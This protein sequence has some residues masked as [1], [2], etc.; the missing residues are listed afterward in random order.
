[1]GQSI[2][3][4]GYW[5]TQTEWVFQAGRCLGYAGLGALAAGLVDALGWLLGHSAA[6]RPLWVLFHAGLMALG[7]ALVVQGRQPLWMSQVARRVW[8]GLQLGRRP[9][10]GVLLVGT[11]WALMPCGLLYSAL[12]LA[13]LSGGPW[14]GAATMGAFALGGGLALL[15][16][17]GVW[18]RFSGLDQAWGTRLAGGLLCADGVFALWMDVREAVN[19][20]C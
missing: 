7:L 16:G 19:L 18:Q 10:W 4:A 13:S 14:Q 2:G 11:A 12:L 8:Q 3:L 20:I 15:A 1:M 17:P 5:P 6:W 9:G